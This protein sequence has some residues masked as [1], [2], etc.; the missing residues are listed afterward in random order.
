MGRPLRPTRKYRLPM[1]PPVTTRLLGRRR[2]S[3]ARIRRRPASPSL[4]RHSRRDSPPTAI[5]RRPVRRRW[6]TTNRLGNPPCSAGELR[7]WETAGQRAVAAHQV[8][9]RPGPAWLADLLQKHGS[10]PTPPAHGSGSSRKMDGEPRYDA[11]SLE[12][13][14]RRH[15]LV[16]RGIPRVSP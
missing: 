4:L 10:A 12:P 2:H 5:P 11:R 1:I 13:T 14:P 3:P 6:M 9:G 7:A 8:L 15:Q 16:F